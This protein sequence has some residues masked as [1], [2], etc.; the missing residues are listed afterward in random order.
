[1][2]RP[3]SRGPQF[4]DDAEADAAVDRT[5]RIDH[6]DRG[7]PTERIDLDQLEAQP[8]VTE[9]IA[10]PPGGEGW[11]YLPP[12]TSTPQLAASP[13]QRSQYTQVLQP[14]PARQTMS[15][16]VQ[17]VYASTEP[18]RPVGSR[19][20]EQ[21][22]WGEPEP[23][24]PVELPRPPERR[25]TA[26]LPVG[27]IMVLAACGALG[28]GTYTLLSTLHVFEILSTRSW[29]P[30]WAA[31]GAIGGG[32]VLAFF[33]F[34]VSCSALARAKPKGPAALLVLAALFL[35]LVATGAG[36]YYGA[37]VLK[38]QT[39]A[40][41]ESFSGQLK[42]GNV[43][44]AL[45]ALESGVSFPGRDDLISILNTVKEKAAEQ[46]VA[47]PDSGSQGA[48]QSGGQ[49]DGSQEGGD[50]QQGEGDSAGGEG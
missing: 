11:G 25:R 31:I 41:A 13:D 46:G 1:M 17:P 29:T 2:S 12:S 6:I 24:P 5:D 49:Q 45:K 48:D 38:T 32:A 34:L 50:G 47:S 42:I 19:V 39:L 9:A 18:A 7:R 22:T 10:M 21:E 28:W 20:S 37:G 27:T 44:Q 14:V 26:A 35:P 30:N 33:A 15:T 40:D 16:P 23:E 8:G 4:D 36:V 3:L 43:D